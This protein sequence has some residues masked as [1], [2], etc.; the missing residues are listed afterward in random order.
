MK[1]LLLSIIILL[2]NLFPNQPSISEQAFARGVAGAIGFTILGIF[3]KLSTKIIKLIKSYFIKNKKSYFEFL[4]KIK[5]KS[6][7]MISYLFN[8]T[9]KDTY[10]EEIKKLNDLR[11]NGIIT[12]E[13][14]EKQKSKLLKSN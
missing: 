4:I 6:L 5:N 7:K 8:F 9:K 12:D 2:G 3:L 13:E 1:K 14:F 10:I 11:I